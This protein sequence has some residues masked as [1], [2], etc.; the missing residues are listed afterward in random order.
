MSAPHDD[1]PPRPV[2]QFMDRGAVAAYL[3]LKSARSLIGVK[4]PPPDVTIGNRKGWMPATIDRWKLSRPGSGRR[5]R[6]NEKVDDA[7]TP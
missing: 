5:P 6:K 1:T 7:S 4:L 2:L 3:G